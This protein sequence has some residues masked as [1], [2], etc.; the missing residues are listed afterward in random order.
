MV[1]V[2][3]NRLIEDCHEP[4]RAPDT[5]IPYRAPDDTEFWCMSDVLYEGLDFVYCIK[6]YERVKM[7]KILW[8]F[9]WAGEASAHSSDVQAV[10][11][12]V[13][14]TK[15]SVIQLY[16]YPHVH[17]WSS[18][19]LYMASFQTSWLKVIENLSP[20]IMYNYSTTTDHL[21]GQEVLFSRSIL[22]S[23][24]NNY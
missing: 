10:P 16:I 22:G 18:Y 2:L 13:T 6:E 1:S 20:S 15:R 21:P 11:N 9:R 5:C 12:G 19:P 3:K 8:E 23:M 17:L 14:D 4:G 24:Y 7:G